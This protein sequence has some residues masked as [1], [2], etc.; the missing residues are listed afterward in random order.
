MVE[1]ASI[2]SLQ[3]TKNNVTIISYYDSIQN[4]SYSPEDKALRWYMPFDW[5]INRLEKD[6]NILVHNEIQVPRMWFGDVE[7]DVVGDNDN[8]TNNGK[9]LSYVHIISFLTCTI[10]ISSFGLFCHSHITLSE[11]ICLL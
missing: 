11:I 4:F 10:C 1:S 3:G 9:L 7:D 8:A 5:N 2:S 6:Q